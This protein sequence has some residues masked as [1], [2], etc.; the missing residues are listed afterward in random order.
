[1]SL[2]LSAAELTARGLRLDQAEAFVAAVAALDPRMTPAQTWQWIARNLLRPEHPM[3]VHEHLHKM[4]FADWDPADG[5]APAWFPEDPQSSNIAWLMQRTGARELPRPARVVHLA[6]GG[7]LGDDDRTP[8]R[9]V[10][11]AFQPRFGPVRWTRTSAVAGRRAAER[12]GELLSSARRF[13]GGDLSGGGWAHRAI[14]RS[15]SCG[16]WS[17]A[18]PMDSLSWE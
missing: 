4:V 14:C 16:P 9:A 6:A 5:P 1:M 3:E 2:V 12:R 11:R 10:P 8:R 18:L 17:T 15:P 7:I 13:N